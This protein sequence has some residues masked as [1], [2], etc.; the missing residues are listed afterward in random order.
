MGFGLGI[1]LVV[2]LSTCGQAATAPQLTAQLAPLVFLLG[3]WDAEGAGQPGVGSGRATFAPDLQGRVLVRTSYAEY[4]ASASG[5][6]SRH[7]DLMVISVGAGGTLQADYYDSEGHEI[8]YAVEVTAPNQAS[9]VSEASP[10]APRYRLQYALAPGGVLKGQ[11][12]IAP[13]GKPEAF[14]SSRRR[15]RRS[16]RPLHS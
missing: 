8:H 15:R 12:D 5:P 9:F 10:N 6:A 2:G 7:D 16:D 1:A 3:A 14:S 13:P 4:P 11:F